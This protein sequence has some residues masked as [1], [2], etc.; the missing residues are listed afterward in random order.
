MTLSRREA[1]AAMGGLA[2][3]D[4]FAHAQA[5]LAPFWKSRIEIPVLRIQ[6]VCFLKE[7]AL[8]RS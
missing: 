3:P 7:G 6:P 8:P 2:L 5:N 4:T 1:P